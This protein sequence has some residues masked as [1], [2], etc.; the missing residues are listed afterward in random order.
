MKIE[1]ARFIRSVVD[2]GGFIDDG[3]PEIA[4]VGRSNVGKSS[5]LNRLL[6]R[7]TLARISSTPGRTRA[8][9]YFLIN[10]GFYFVDLPG[11]GYARVSKSERRIWA[12]LMESYFRTVAQRAMVIHIVDAKVGATELDIQASDY[13]RSAGLEPTIVAT[14]TDRI[15]RSRVPRA[16]SGIRRS[17][18]LAELGEVIPFSARTGLG[19]KELWAEI[20]R[21]LEA[22]SRPGSIRGMNDD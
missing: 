18:G 22:S 12:D 16:I 17:L 14:K 9:N 3:H 7:K 20:D 19:V 21:Y 11:Y 8:V 1:T 13:V 10:E 6:K 5:L 15:G 4:F 2:S